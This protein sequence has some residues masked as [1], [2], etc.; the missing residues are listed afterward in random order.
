MEFT[1]K[2]FYI[3]E[4]PSGL[5]YLGQTMQ[6]LKFYTGSGYHWKQ[7]IKE[8]GKPTLIFSRWC[9]T[10]EE[11]QK[12]L[13][14]VERDY[15]RYWESDEWSNAIPETPWNGVKPME[16]RKHTAATRLKISQRNFAN[17][18]QL[19]ARMLGDKNPMFGKPSKKRKGIIC[20]SLGLF[21]VDRNEAAQYF[22]YTP[23]GIKNM[24]TG[25][26]KNVLN[27]YFAD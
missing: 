12:I 9:N 1:P 3:F 27:I 14:A 17:S 8:V 15:P 16:G 18:E 13:T 7:H 11:F 21:F 25:Q 10:P 23:S 6:D 2:W 4:S 24:L 5:L 19:S 26:Q 20:D 22:G